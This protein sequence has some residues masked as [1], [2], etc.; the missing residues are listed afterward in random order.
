MKKRTKITDI[1]PVGRHL[2]DEHLAS[3]IGG[4]V[5]GGPITNKDTLSLNSQGM[6][7]HN[8]DVQQ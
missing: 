5:G 1:S 6:P 4:F 3:V 8:T 7:D 2:M